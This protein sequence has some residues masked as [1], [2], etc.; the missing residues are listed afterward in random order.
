M[1]ET[2]QTVSSVYHVCSPKCTHVHLVCILRNVTLFLTVT[3]SRP[4]VSQDASRGQAV[5]KRSLDP[6]GMN[7]GLS[8]AGGHLG[9]MKRADRNFKIPSP[10]SITMAEVIRMIQENPVG[11]LPTSR[12]SKSTGSPISVS[13]QQRQLRYVRFS[14]QQTLLMNPFKY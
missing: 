2:A 12:Q 3:L 5:R 13:T 1:P 10:V 7:I 6:T 8:W 9:H 11:R 4:F 14:V